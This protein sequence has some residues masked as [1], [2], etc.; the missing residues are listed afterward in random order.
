MMENDPII[1]DLCQD[2]LPGFSA[3]IF[4][5][6]LMDPKWLPCVATHAIAHMEGLSGNHGK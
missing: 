2:F 3:R 6:H 5:Q 4:C 1:G